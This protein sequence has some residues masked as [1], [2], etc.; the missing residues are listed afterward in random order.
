MKKSVT[1]ITMVTSFGFLFQAGLWSQEENPVCRFV[2]LKTIPNIVLD[3]RYAT[4]NNFTGKIVYTKAEAFLVQPA[5]EALELVQKELA[6]SG[7]GLKIYDAY[8]PLSVQKI[9][10]EIM[11]DER[12]VADPAKG[13]RHNRGCAVDCTLINL[14][15]GKEL[16][17]PTEFDDFTEKAH[18]DSMAHSPEVLKNRDTLEKIM[19]KHGFVGISTEWWHFDFEGWEQYPLFAQMPFAQE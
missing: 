5:A 15:D 2:D 17:M 19:T 10:W 3:I 11:P 1:L 16:E 12:Y 13:S 14:S 7:L 4:T 8:R 6:E 18:R 9:F